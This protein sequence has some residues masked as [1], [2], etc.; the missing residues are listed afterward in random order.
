MA[1]VVGLSI[2]M[3][4]YLDVRRMLRDRDVN[5]EV[6]KRV[7]KKGLVDIKAADIKVGHFIQVETDRRVRFYLFCRFI[8]N[9]NF[10]F[11]F[12]LICY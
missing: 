5:H 4:G 9:I 10:L 2:V 1:F 8:L 6:Y 7:T 11:R 3:E 12:L